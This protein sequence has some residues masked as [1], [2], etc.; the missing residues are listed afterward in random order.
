MHIAGLT[1]DR[2]EGM[3]EGIIAAS[4]LPEFSL[5]QQI[6]KG[7]RHAIHADPILP[8]QRIFLDHRST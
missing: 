6:A 8:P 4:L 3:T 5:G 1:G 2:V 7:F